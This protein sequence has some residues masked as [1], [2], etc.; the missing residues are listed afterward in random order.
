MALREKDLREHVVRRYALSLGILVEGVADNVPSAPAMQFSRS[1]GSANGAITNGT[2]NSQPIGSAFHPAIRPLRAAHLFECTSTSSEL[3]GEWPVYFG[4]KACGALR[5]LDKASMEM[6]V[7]KVKQL[8]T[9]FFSPDNQV[10]LQPL[11]FICQ[12]NI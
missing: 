2:P 7:R 1:N 8:S 11:L 10:Q 12:P 5:Q 6:G 9:G 4:S 3:L